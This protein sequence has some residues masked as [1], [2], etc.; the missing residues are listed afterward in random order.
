M[1]RALTYL[2]T[3]GAGFIGSHL[4]DRLLGEGHTVIA[5]D[6]FS[7]GR[8]QNVGHLLEHPHFRMVRGSALDAD[9]LDALMKECDGCF[10][11][12]AA[13][14]VQ[15]IVEMP[16][17][18]MATNID[19]AQ[20]LLDAAAHY[21]RPVLITSSSEVYGKGSR[22]PFR[23]DDDVIMGPTSVN[24]WS[25]AYSKGIVE[26][27]A[28]AY[29]RERRLPTTI[30]RLFNTVGPRQLGQHGMVLPRFVHAALHNEPLIVHGD[31][32]QTRCFCHVSDVTSALVRLMQTSAAAGEVFNVGSDEEISIRELAERVIRHSG[33]SSSIKHVA[34][35]SIYGPEFDDIP[36]RVPSL[37][38][39]R[40]AIAFRCHFDLDQLLAAIIQEAQRP[41]LLTQ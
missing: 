15:R 2:I 3:G 18:S 36:R 33:S 28:L 9:A 14:G 35:H 29:W 31:G 10:H 5:L 34:H 1:S 17:R 23:E 19:G 22:I 20:I 8:M 41:A 21:G 38:K 25:Y 16:L 26:F 13:L 11:L 37:E 27:M 24:R 12:A 4:A 6:D 40:S 7:T 32:S 30:V 39:I